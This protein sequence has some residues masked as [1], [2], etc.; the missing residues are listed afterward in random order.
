MSTRKNR[1]TTENPYDTLFIRPTRA[2]EDA[3][4]DDG[5]CWID[6]ET[7]EIVCRARKSPEPSQPQPPWPNEPEPSPNSGTPEASRK[8]R[9]LKTFGQLVADLLAPEPIAPSSTV[10]PLPLPQQP[11]RIQF[12]AE[13]PLPVRSL[14]IRRPWRDGPIQKLREIRR[15][16]QEDAQNRLQQAFSNRRE[17][18]Q[19][20]LDIMRE[21]TGNAVQRPVTHDDEHERL[22]V[23]EINPPQ[24]DGAWQAFR[25]LLDPVSEPSTL[26]AEAQPDYQQAVRHPVSAEESLR[27]L[28]ARELARQQVEMHQ[29]LLREQIELA[30]AQQ[31]AARLQQWAA[32]V[33]QKLQQSTRQ[34]PTPS[35]P[36]THA[37]DYLNRRQKLLN[38]LFNGPV[39]DRTDQQFPYDLQAGQKVDDRNIVQM[40]AVV[41]WLLFAQQTEGQWSDEKVQLLEERL[42]SGSHS[43]IS[44]KI[45]RQLEIARQ[46][47]DILKKNEEISFQ[48]DDARAFALGMQVLIDANTH[49]G[50]V[51]EKQLIEDMK[52]FMI[53]QKYNLLGIPAKYLHHFRPSNAAYNLFAGPRIGAI[54]WKE[55][56]WDHGQQYEIDKYGHK[57]LINQVHHF[58]GFFIVGLENPDW[59]RT[60]AY[61]LDGIRVGDLYN[62]NDLSLSELSIYLARSI[63]RKTLSWKDFPEVI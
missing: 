40:A 29:Q 19:T 61:L 8:D 63:K 7:G 28:Q 22:P 42:F 31:K 41:D 18:R 45:W 25:Q 1:V 14:Q 33:I 58:A 4:S 12:P 62:P 24:N 39:F 35:S 51:D 57:K 60:E 44:P 43:V 15:K 9:L 36:S 47:N 10:R 11:A 16:A 32:Q 5:E 30:Q 37:K 54:G 48:R 38:R 6:P 20:R 56:Y 52:L 27:R 21:I 2:N 23:V 53:D 26:I 46:L 55:K 3:F 17:A 13:A 50:A 59:A 49:N 34:T